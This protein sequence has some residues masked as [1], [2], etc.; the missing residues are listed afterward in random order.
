VRFHR[1]TAPGDIPADYDEHAITVTP[2]KA[3]AAGVRAVMASL[4]RGLEQMGALRTAAALARLDQRQGFDCPGR[5]W[6]EEH[7]GRKLAE[8]CENGAKAVAEEAT[9]RVR[10]PCWESQHSGFADNSAT[11]CR[12]EK[13]GVTA[14]Y[15]QTNAL[16][17]LDHTADKSNTRVSKA[18]TI[19][20]EP[21]A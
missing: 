4:Q 18:I 1:S 8:F 15:P 13:S 21:A 9:K 5:A 10:R 14:H 20:V 6:P 19:R 12:A 16:V 17:P 7:G 2:R 11:E 3:E